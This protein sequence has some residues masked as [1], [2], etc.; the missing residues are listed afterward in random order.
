M[1]VGGGSG[2]TLSAVLKAF[3]DLRG[4]VFD[5]PAATESAAKTLTAEGLADRADV[6][7]GSFFDGISPAGA[8]G[9]LLSEVLHDWDDQ[10]CHQILRHCA[11]AAGPDGKVFIVEW[12]GDESA[13][14]H[15]EMD[16]RMLTYYGG[17]ER[18]LPAL[19]A[20]AAHAGLDVLGVHKSGV[21]TVLE[22][23]GA[24]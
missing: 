14:V 10:A 6:V 19:T 17:R 11:E 8:G 16:L 21:L 4:T 18:N 1:D 13:A 12:I 2:I 15:T 9:Y 22:L 20:L 7:A 3:P 24:R 5:L 23:G